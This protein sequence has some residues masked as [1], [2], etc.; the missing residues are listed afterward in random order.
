MLTSKKNLFQ[1]A[2]IVILTAVAGSISAQDLF[3]AKIYLQG[4]DKGVLL[5]NYTNG[6]RQEGDLQILTHNYN[7]PNGS[8]F[9]RE[10]L[11]LKNGEMIDHRTEFYPLK[12]FSRLKR[13]DK[14]IEISFRRGEKSRKKIIPY[15]DG[16]VYGPTQQQYIRENLSKFKAGEVLTFYLPAPEFR[17]IIS[18]TM[19]KIDNTI[20]NRPGVIVLQ[21]GTRNIILR[22]IIGKNQFV[23]DENTGTILEIHGPSI[24]KRLVDGKWKY[25]DTDIY[26]SYSD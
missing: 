5:F 9:A 16:I 8:L 1:I 20:Y 12:E 21:M 4:S 7:T 23:V 18:F 6:I 11:I 10:E 24:L 3:N 14:G 15:R 19:R 22:L 17:T 2:L 25:V 13:V 26:F